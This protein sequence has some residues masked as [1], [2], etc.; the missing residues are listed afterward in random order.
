MQAIRVHQYGGAHYLSHSS[1]ALKPG[2]TCL[3]RA[4]AGGVGQLLCQMAKLAGAR[5][6]GTLSTKEKAAIA[7]EAGADEVIN[8]AEKDFAEEVKRLTGGNGVQ[9]VYDGVGKDTFNKGLDCLAPRGCMVLFGGS[10]GPVPLFDPAVLAQNGS[11]F[12]H[13]P[14]LADFTATR[15]ELVARSNELLGWVQ[16]GKLRVKIAATFPLAEAAAAHRLLVSRSSA[17]KILLIS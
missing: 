17:G 5:V 6:I 4:A 1:Y 10:S 8:Y 16:S 14:K 12:L 15:E 2:D 13:R 9:V 11:L 7:L 3:V